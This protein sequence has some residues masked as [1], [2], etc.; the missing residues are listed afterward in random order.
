[1]TDDYQAEVNRILFEAIERA[2]SYT[3][4]VTADEADAIQSEALTAINA[5]F[6]KYV[7]GEDLEFADEGDA[8]GAIKAIEKQAVNEK[9][10]EQRSIIRKEKKDV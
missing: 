1:M 5:A 10:A 8:H 7:I 9:L 6:E 2:A 4:R 3:H